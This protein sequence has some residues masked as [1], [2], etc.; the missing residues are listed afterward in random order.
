MIEYLKIL[1]LGVGAAVVYGVLHDQVTARLCVE[2]FT[3]FHVKVVETTSPTLLALVWGVMGTWWVAL[4]LAVPVALFARVGRRPKLTARDLL[5]PVLVLMLAMAVASGTGGVLGYAR[6]EAG[7]LTVPE[8]FA[9][10]IPA[11][12]HSLFLAD[13]WAHRAS[14]GTAYFGS[15]VLWGWCSYRR[16]RLEI[17]ERRTIRPRQLREPKSLGPT[18]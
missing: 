1:A 7:A 14:Y 8:P 15:I 9:S 16:I 18:S 17:T 2:Y 10:R 4:L 5:V 11:E 6:A 3:V 12:K 13:L